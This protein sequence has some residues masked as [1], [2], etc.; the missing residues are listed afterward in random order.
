[1][2][3]T[4]KA[5][6]PFLDR[7]PRELHEQYITD[8]VTEFMKLAETNKTTNDVVTSIKYGLIVAFARKS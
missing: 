2:S 4:L 8:C 6:N 1:M 7:M 5:V 3:D